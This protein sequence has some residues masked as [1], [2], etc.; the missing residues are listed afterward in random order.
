MMTTREDPT[1]RDLPNA[2]SATESTTKGEPAKKLDPWHFGAH[3]VP[4]NLR[5]E[6]SNIELPDA[7]AERRYRP[8][9]P[10]VEQ[11]EATEE[12]RI[13]KRDF[14]RSVTVGLFALISVLSLAAAVR[15]ATAETDDVVLP[16]TPPGA[17]QPRNEVPAVATPATTGEVAG[18]PSAVEPPTRET[19]AA[20]VS[21]SKPTS[22][23]S[24]KPRP[25]SAATRPGSVL[26]EDRPAA[27]TPPPSSPPSG[28]IVP[29][30]D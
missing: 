25:P 8:Q 17:T 4:P 26:Q 3:T 10:A 27:P 6:L 7:P 19:P 2:A 11:A 30:E 29:A 9:A 16:S 21:A 12:L 24:V 1:K 18:Q 22:A 28:R 15:C 14:R 5:A 20:S 23:G 13:P